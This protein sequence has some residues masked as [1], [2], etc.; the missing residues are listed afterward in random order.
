[1]WEYEQRGCVVF[2]GRIAHEAV[3]DYL[4]AADVLLSPHVPMPDGRPFIGSPTK[5]F[6]YM[7]M[8]KAIVASRLDQLEKVLTHN[9]TALLV[10]P[11]DAKQLAAA[12]RLA[13]GN[14]GLRDRLGRQARQAALRNHTWKANAAKVLGAAGLRSATCEIAS[15]SLKEARDAGRA[16]TRNSA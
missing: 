3:P 8:G 12:I 7:A 1:L 9:E 4:N 15:V 2:A 14:A 10:E 13:A 6:E 11:G 16:R 5:L